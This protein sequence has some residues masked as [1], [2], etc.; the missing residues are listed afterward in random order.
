[1]PVCIYLFMCMYVYMYACK[2]LFI[3]VYVCMYVC[4]SA[5]GA[6][7]QS[8]NQPDHHAV[9]SDGRLAKVIHISLHQLFS[10]HAVRH[11][12]SSLISA[13]VAT[14]FTRPVCPKP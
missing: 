9:K 10:S 6:F 13:T 5:N 8:S 4:T 12:F 1:M 14:A 2:Y 7:N 3:Y 11:V